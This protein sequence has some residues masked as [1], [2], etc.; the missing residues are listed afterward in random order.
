MDLLK[1]LDRAKICLINTNLIN[2]DTIKNLCEG[3]KEGKT[4]TLFRHAI[5]E[6]DHVISLQ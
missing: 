3:A 4:M 2:E 1:G 6:D 5:L